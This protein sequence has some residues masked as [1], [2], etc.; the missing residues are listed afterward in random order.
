MRG[1]GA[2][3]VDVKVRRG[4]YRAADRPN[5]GGYRGRA[6]RESRFSGRVTC[7]TLH[8]SMC[9]PRRGQKPAWGWRGTVRSSHSRWFR[10]CRLV[11]M[12]NMG[13]TDNKWLVRSAG[14]GTPWWSDLE[15]VGWQCT[16]SQ[17]GT[18]DSSDT[19]SPELWR[20]Q[21]PEDRWIECVWVRANGSDYLQAALWSDHDCRAQLEETLFALGFNVQIL[22]MKALLTD[23]NN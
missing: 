17:A 1:V 18:R 12:I 23:V 7:S 2:W 4:R 3:C 20:I 15:R 5:V 9:P 22:D 14:G 10:E 21:S 16:R 11:G 6:R 19:P 13:T 8:H